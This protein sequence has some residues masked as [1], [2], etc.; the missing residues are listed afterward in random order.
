MTTN[1]P[2]T[3]KQFEALVKLVHLGNYVVNSF[4]GDERLKEYDELEQ[5]V[6]S[7]SKEAGLDRRV[8]KDKDGFFR[9]SETLEDETHQHGNRYD[10]D[11]FWDTLI[12]L[13][14]LR[15]MREEHG[16]KELEEMN[17]E[18]YREARSNAERRYEHEFDNY[19]VDRIR[20]EKE[21]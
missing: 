13:L 20:V 4:R 2:F 9:L 6:L 12:E 18:E 16:K 11:V 21:E 7:F 5:H 8:P 19:G 3:K 1:V 10:D 15:D 17:D 14:A